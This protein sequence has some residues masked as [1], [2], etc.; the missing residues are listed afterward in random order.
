MSA[1]PVEGWTRRRF[2][3]GLTVAGTAGRLG[4]HINAFRKR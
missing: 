1:Q 2:I 3:G 4:W